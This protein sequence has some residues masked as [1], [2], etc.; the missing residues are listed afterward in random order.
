MEE[1]GPAWL[2]DAGGNPGAPLP[3]SCTLKGLFCGVS[4][5]NPDRLTPSPRSG[6]AECFAGPHPLCAV[7][8]L[9]GVG[10]GV[11][12]RKNFPAEVFTAEVSRGVA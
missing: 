3:P 11:R 2:G 4:P 1:K 10:G 9:G 12:P 8:F 7:L 6:N 5:S